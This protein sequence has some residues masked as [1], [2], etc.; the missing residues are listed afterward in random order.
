MFY[1][2]FLQFALQGATVHA[3]TASR[4]GNIAVIF[5]QNPLDMFP[6]K[7]LHRGRTFA[8]PGCLGGGIGIERRE[9]ILH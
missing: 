6:L 5:C 7:T 8:D 2:P 9:D 3:E 1:R 4:G